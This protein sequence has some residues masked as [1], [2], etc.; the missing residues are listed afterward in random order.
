MNT[1]NIKN[2]VSYEKICNG[3]WAFTATRSDGQKITRIQ[4]IRGGQVVAEKA[5]VIIGASV[6]R[7]F[8]GVNGL[9]DAMAEGQLRKLV[10]TKTYKGINFSFGADQK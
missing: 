2:G 3:K 6:K 8:A 5:A 10:P 7:S 9:L 4:K 1:T